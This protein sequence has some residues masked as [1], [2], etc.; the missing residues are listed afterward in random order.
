MGYNIKT[1]LKQYIYEGVDWINLAEYGPAVDFVMSIM[2]I[3]V[4]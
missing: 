2:N 3:L 1:D 4:P